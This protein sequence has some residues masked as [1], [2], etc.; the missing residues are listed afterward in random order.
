MKFYVLIP[1]DGQRFSA[2][3]THAELVSP[4]FGEGDLCPACGA[5][6]NMRK[7]L[8]PHNIRLSSSDP[9]KWGDF[10]WG[11][12]FLL[13]VSERFAKAYLEEGLSGIRI[14]HPPATISKI[15]KHYTGSA[16]HPLPA[17]QLIDVEWNGAN[18]DDTVSGLV[19]ENPD[20]VKCSY[21]RT[22]GF[23]LRQHGVELEPNSWTGVDIFTPR[24]APVELLISER[25]RLAFEKHRLT[26]MRVVPAEMFAYDR[27]RPGQWYV[28]GEQASS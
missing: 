8:P 25:A 24:G 17:Y 10:V 4:Q 21:C 7:P 13:F 27:L 1:E 11:A 15:G 12:D 16:I 23:L 3:W 5:P 26:N 14:F 9:K 20:G 22:G 6:V 28:R 18:Q 2:N 19:N